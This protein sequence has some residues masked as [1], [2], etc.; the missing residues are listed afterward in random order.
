MPDPKP[1]TE[2]PAEPIVPIKEVDDDD[3][4]GDNG[5]GRDTVVVPN[6]KNP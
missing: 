6:P 4:T 5:G 2:E 3:V 1:K